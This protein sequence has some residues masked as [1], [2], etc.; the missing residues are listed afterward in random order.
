MRKFSKR[1]KSENFESII[2]YKTMKKKLNE[3][4]EKFLK[5]NNA[6]VYS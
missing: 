4:N 5:L 1:M 6:K 2:V 3:E